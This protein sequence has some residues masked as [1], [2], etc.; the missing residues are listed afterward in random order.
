[1][2]ILNLELPAIAPGDYQACGL[3]TKVN[4]DPLNNA[5]W[6]QLNCK[7]FQFQ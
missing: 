2:H 4:S 1:M 5:N 7:E 6:L 3:I